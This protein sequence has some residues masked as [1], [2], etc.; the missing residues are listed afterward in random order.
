MKIVYSLDN[1]QFQDKQK[2]IFLLLRIKIFWKNAYKMMEV[3]S[4]I[5]IEY[6]FISL[7]STQ[8]KWATTY[9]EILGTG[10]FV[11]LF[12]ARSK[13]Q[14]ILQ[15]FQLLLVPSYSSLYGIF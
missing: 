4:F 5:N 7:I 14:L 9:F 11:L 12:T 10:S 2:H 8:L 13:H 3:E 1:T 6:S 15:R